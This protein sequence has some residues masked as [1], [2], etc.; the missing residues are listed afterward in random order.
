M[1]SNLTDFISFCIRRYLCMVKEKYD[2]QEKKKN[3]VTIEERDKA[4]K[5]DL[6]EFMQQTGLELKRDSDKWYRSVEH[7]SLVV[8]RVKNT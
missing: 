2:K 1:K 3:F 8:N 4:L 6:V 7:D 5:V